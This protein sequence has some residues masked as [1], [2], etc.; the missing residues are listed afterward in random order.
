MCIMPERSARNAHFW[1]WNILMTTFVEWSCQRN[2][3]LDACTDGRC[4]T[5]IR[6]DSDCLYLATRLTFY[7]MRF[8]DLLLIESSFYGIWGYFCLFAECYS[9][10]LIFHESCAKVNLFLLPNYWRTHSDCQRTVFLVRALWQRS[11]F[12]PCRALCAPYLRWYTS[13]HSSCGALSF[14]GRLWEIGLFWV[15]NI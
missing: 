4:G 9:V 2:A 15:A 1:Q 7:K 5:L 6:L 13:T 14:P 12:E 11:S 3:N 10:I 8:G